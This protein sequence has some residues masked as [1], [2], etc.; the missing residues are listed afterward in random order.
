MRSHGYVLLDL[1][2]GCSLMVL[3]LLPLFGELHSWLTRRNERLTDYL[4][5]AEV[6]ALRDTLSFQHVAGVPRAMIG[7]GEFSVARG[8]EQIWRSSESDGRTFR[9]RWQRGEE[10]DWVHLEVEEDGVP[11]RVSLPLPAAS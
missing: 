10:V 5:H 8:E 4:L 2:A 6:L 9:L 11:C 7:G 1:L 3:V